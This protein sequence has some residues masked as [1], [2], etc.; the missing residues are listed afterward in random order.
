MTVRKLRRFF[1]MSETREIPNVG[2][3]ERERMTFIQ[4]R[5]NLMHDVCRFILQERKREFV[6][7]IRGV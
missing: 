5:S 6:V 1:S 2:L 4:N 7:K 3:F